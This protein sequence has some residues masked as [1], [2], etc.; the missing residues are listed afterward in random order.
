M[1]RVELPPGA[2][3][4]VPQRDLLVGGPSDQRRHRLARAALLGHLLRES[5]VQDAFNDWTIRYGLRQPLETLTTRLD[6]IAFDAGLSSRTALF[7]PE[8]TRDA[9][10]QHAVHEAYEA[11]WIGVNGN[12][13]ELAR[14]GHRLAEQLVTALGLAEVCIAWLALELLSW[15]CDSL[16]AQIENRAVTRRY[17][18]EPFSEVL[19]V[20]IDRRMSAREQFR[21]IQQQVANQLATATKQSAASAKRMPKRGGRHIATYVEWLVQHGL[22]DVR[23]PALARALLRSER[24]VPRSSKY[25]ARRRIQY[26]I[27]QARTL[28]AAVARLPSSRPAQ[29]KRRTTRKSST[30]RRRRS[31]PAR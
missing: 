3:P 20:R 23:V 27:G 13:V 14:D 16:R 9:S 28:L 4:F 11:F 5:K 22:H 25:D 26:G 30:P 7:P 17:T 6:T 24:D 19:T 18:E 1:T 21:D 31:S 29:P 8:S 2:R 12:S 10:T 15:F